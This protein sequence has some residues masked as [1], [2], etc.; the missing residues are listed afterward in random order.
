MGHSSPVS[1]LHG[2][3]NLLSQAEKG[4]FVTSVVGLFEEKIAECLSGDILHHDQDAMSIVLL[5]KFMNSTNVRVDK[6]FDA[7]ET[8]QK[9]LIQIGVKDDTGAQFSKRHLCS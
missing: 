5:Q 9:C 7:L 6:T 1:M 3:E 2:R 4:C 8:L